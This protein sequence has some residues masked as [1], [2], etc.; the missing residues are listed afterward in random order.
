MRNVFID[1]NK[2][3]KDLIKLINLEFKSN[4]VGNVLYQNCGIHGIRVRGSVLE[5][6]IIYRAH[7]YKNTW[8]N[9]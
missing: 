1:S 4:C 6:Q 2:I 8:G 7:I 9:F 3:D 5:G